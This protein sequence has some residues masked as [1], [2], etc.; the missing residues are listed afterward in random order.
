MDTPPITSDRGCGKLE[1][2]K[3][4]QQQQQDIGIAIH[5]LI[6]IEKRN[7]CCYAIHDPVPYSATTKNHNATGRCYFQMGDFIAIDFD[8]YRRPS[9][10]VDFL[11]QHYQHRSRVRPKSHNEA[12]QI[13][14]PP[15]IAGTNAIHEGTT[16]TP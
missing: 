12:N 1:D 5:N 10:N 4:H 8:D 7:D 13:E 11:H 3:W 2:E 14:W 9:T 16:T 6:A 15:K